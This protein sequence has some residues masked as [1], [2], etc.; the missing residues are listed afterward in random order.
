VK[1]ARADQLLTGTV[2]NTR[3]RDGKPIGLEGHGGRGW[4]GEDEL[5][6]DRS[7]IPATESNVSL[8]VPFGFRNLLRHVHKN[9]TASTGVPIIVTENGFMVKDEAMAPMENVVNDVDR[10]TFFNG[11][12][13]ELAEAVRDDGIV[14][15]GYMGWSLLESVD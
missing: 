14:I 11:Y 15:G 2:A 12:I 5:H 3:H 13:K 8:A 9:Y 4:S 10:Q 6:M 1:G 7:R